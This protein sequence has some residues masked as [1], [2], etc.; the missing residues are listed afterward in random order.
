MIVMQGRSLL[1]GY[2][3][4]KK[5]TAGASSGSWAWRILMLTNAAGGLNKQ[6]H[7][8]HDADQ[9]PHQLCRHGGRNPLRSQRSRTWPPLLDMSRT[10]D[11]GNCVNRAGKIATEESCRCIRRHVPVW[12][13][14]FW[15][16]PADALPR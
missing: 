13:G 16:L 12:L 15:C 6:Y 11:I 10:I 8:R 14:D 1:R 4:A 2:S 9:R 5:V 7:R 3:I